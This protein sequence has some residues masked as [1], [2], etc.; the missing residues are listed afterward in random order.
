MVFI[1]WSTWFKLM[2]YMFFFE[3]V[4]FC[5][6]TSSGKLLFGRFKLWSTH[7]F[8]G[9]NLWSTY[10]QNQHKIYDSKLWSTSILMLLTLR[11]TFWGYC[12]P[13]VVLLLFSFIFLPFS[14]SSILKQKKEENEKN[15]WKGRKKGKG[16]KKNTRETKKMTNKDCFFQQQ[17]QNTNQNNN[18]QP[19]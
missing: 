2:I 15:A 19:K 11:S 13:S 18:T 7:F 1:L 17:Q 6:K 14:A 5:R 16:K 10:P 9:V 4:L 8:D 12:F 3:N